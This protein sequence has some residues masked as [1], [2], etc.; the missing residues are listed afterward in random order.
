MG[1][2]GMQSS[3]GQ[4]AGGPDASPCADFKVGKC[5]RGAACKFSHAMCGEFKKGLCTRGSTCKFA[6][7]GVCPG[8][9]FD[10]DGKM[11]CGQFK[12]GTCTRGDACKFS[13]REEAKT[14]CGDF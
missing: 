2:M 7:A 5:L 13:H 14:V 3:S 11:I 8:S 9:T 12:K 6:H 1:G 10:A 4:T